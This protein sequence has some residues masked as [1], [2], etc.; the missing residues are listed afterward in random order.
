MVRGIFSLQ[1]KIF[2][3]TLTRSVIKNAV[4]FAIVL[5][6]LYA[7]FNIYTYSLIRYYLNENLDFKISHE[8]DHIS[9]AFKFE[10]E[11]LIIIKPSEFDETDLVEITEDPYFLQIYT[12]GGKLLLQ[13]KNLSKFKTI[14]LKFPLFKEQYFFTDA[15][16][17][18]TALRCGYKKIFNEKGEQAA[19]LQLSSLKSNFNTILKNIILLNLITFPIV[20][21]II[22]GI[23]IFVSRRAYSPI[24][25][26]IKL[27]NNISTVHLNERLNYDADSNDELGKLR[28]TLNNLFERLEV[29]VKNISFFTDNASHQLM[30]PITAIKTE[31]EYLMR[32]QITTEEYKQS[33]PLLKEQTDRM[34]NIIQSLLILAKSEKDSMMH[35][36]VFNL[37]RLLNEQIKNIFSANNIRYQI[38]DDIYI[39]GREDYFLQVLNNLVDNAIKYSPENEN[40]ELRVKTNNNKIIVEVADIGKG[41]KDSEKEKIFER[42]YRS[43]EVEKLGIKGYGLGLSIVK[44]IVEVMGGSIEVKDNLP[45]GSLFII[46]LPLIKVT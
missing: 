3:I 24:N 41:I 10:R 1:I 12:N 17:N 28:D 26:I 18:D 36:S 34:T 21:I 30:T 31:L 29:Q 15:S 8:I 19:I 42:F 43:R 5:L 9:Y 6:I 27:A 20:I 25:K 2:N 7:S 13:S 32:D 37:S 40:I 16:S 46:T 11:T 23:S 44:S 39:R 38:E 45:H 4:I 35:K 14:E 22:V 33:L